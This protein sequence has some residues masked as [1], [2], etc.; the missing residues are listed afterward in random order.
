[1]GHPL[2]MSWSSL[3]VILVCIILGIIILAFILLF[4]TMDS[5]VGGVLSGLLVAIFILGWRE[6]WI[7][8]LM[9]WFEK[10]EYKGVNI[11][12]RWKG[13]WSKGKNN[14]KDTW[15]ITQRAHV[16]EATI[17]I[18]EGPDHGK[19]YKFFGELK[20]L[21]FTGIYESSDRNALDRGSYALQIENNG[22]SL[23][24]HCL[25]YEDDTNSIQSYTYHCQRSI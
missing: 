8:I 19:S 22:G 9:P 21:I 10:R 6:I 23:I 16:I 12:G 20:N 2:K 15:E 18:T 7:K 11:S 5:V 17:I 3:L 14:R 24:G 4:T 25:M 13:E 1:M